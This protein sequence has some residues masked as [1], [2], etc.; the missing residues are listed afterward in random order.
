MNFTPALRRNVP[1][2]IGIAGPSGGGKTY[3]ALRLARGLADGGSIAAIDTERGRM[4]HYADE[5][6]FLHAELDAPFSPD[7]YADAIKEA[8]A[9][10][11]AV[12]LIDSF[13]HEWAGD[14]GV[15]DMQEAELD[16][17]AGNDWK[18]R[19]A[20]RFASWIKPKGLHKTLVND[21]ITRMPCHLILCLR[22]ED[23]V[24]MKKDPKTGKLEVVPKRTL[25]GHEGWIPVTGKEVAYELTVSLV[26]TPDKP[27]VPQPVKIQA[28]HI[29]LVPLDRPLDES[30]GQALAAWAKGSGAESRAPAAAGVIP[31][32]PSAA[33]GPA[34][35][36]SAT[37]DGATDSAL[38]ATA[39][40]FLTDDQRD[41]LNE[42]Q[43]G[44]SLPQLIATLAR[45]RGVN[46]DTIA[47]SEWIELREQLTKSEAASWIERMSEK[48]PA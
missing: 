17:M 20:V 6:E 40:V 47:A 38:P 30:V 11:P 42:L 33:E 25:S 27:G 22:A 23:R 48:V 34:P 10:A 24:E 15:I 26:V 9:L 28:Q 32:T 43:R 29:P 18:K 21:V 7:R 13:S 46:A 35:S 44:F 16:R 31:S 14:G 8:L 3:S 19:E 5:F 12:I 37:S 36:S 2:I 39:R 41:T 4:L 45:D 1:L